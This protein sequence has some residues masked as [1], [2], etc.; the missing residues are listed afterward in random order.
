VTDD[1]KDI[2]GQFDKENKEDVH[3]K[4]KDEHYTTAK[5][6]EENVTKYYNDMTWHILESLYK[7][8]N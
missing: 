3:E 7:N 8:F 5:A 2:Y 6:R 1:I 4:I